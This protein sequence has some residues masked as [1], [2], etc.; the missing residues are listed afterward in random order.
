MDTLDSTT[1]Q[2]AG[3][4]RRS[5]ARPEHGKHMR[6]DVPCCLRA[7]RDQYHSLPK[8]RCE[9]PETQLGSPLFSFYSIR[10]S[11]AFTD[12][13]DNL[14]AFVD[15]ADDLLPRGTS[16]AGRFRQRTFLT[17]AEPPQFQIGS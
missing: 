3:Y 10:P 6:S 14:L 11:Y 7:G 17:V 9:D 1:S 2:L 12:A 5:R 13:V 15:E 8:N 4:A 16:G